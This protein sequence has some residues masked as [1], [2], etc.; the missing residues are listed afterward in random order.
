MGELAVVRHETWETTA[1]SAPVVSGVHKGPGWRRTFLRHLRRH[2]RITFACDAAGVSTALAYKIRASSPRFA[3]AW[4]DARKEARQK[5]IDTL[6]AEAFR[7]AVEGWLEPVFS[8]G[9]VVAY[10]RRFSEKCLIMLLEAYHPRFRRLARSRGVPAPRPRAAIAW[11]P[12][13][14]ADN[15]E[16][17]R[18]KATIAAIGAASRQPEAALPGPADGPQSKDEMTP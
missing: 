17:I 12:P 3:A 2:G 4:N 15:P 16:Y 14:V 5:M 1:F 6:E 13:D 7:R 8:G 10:R 11:P 9:R 18:A